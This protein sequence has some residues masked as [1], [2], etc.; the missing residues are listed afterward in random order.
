MLLALTVGLIALVTPASA[1]SA[2]SK[3]ALRFDGYGSAQLGDTPGE[4]S[5]KLD[6]PMECHY[7]GGP[8]VCS[9]IGE[10]RGSIVFVYQLD[11]Q[12]GLDL[13]FT[14]SRQVVASRGLQV[15]DSLGRMR[16]LFPHAHET[17]QAGYSGYRRFVVGNGRLGILGELHR[18]HIV[19]LIA[20]KRR[21]FDY[22]EFCS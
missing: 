9:S 15:G 13:V 16:K 4:V 10:G 21:F 1:G 5:E 2:A 6:V 14:G 20:G 19:E 18:G 22:V 8:C 11:G 12:A 17:R 3:P 7:L